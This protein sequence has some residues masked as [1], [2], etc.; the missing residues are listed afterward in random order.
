MTNSAGDAGPPCFR[1]RPGG[2]RDATLY[3][4]IAP[5]E[6][7]S[8]TNAQRRAT[9]RTRPRKAPADKP[10]AETKRASGITAL[11]AREL[12]AKLLSTPTIADCTWAAY[13]EANSLSERNDG[14]SR[15]DFINR[16]L[17]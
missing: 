14:E 6:P 15:T 5:V 13:R 7:V 8:T 17:A 12:K 2:F 10:A 1:G 11:P 16:V 4:G 9:F 3:D